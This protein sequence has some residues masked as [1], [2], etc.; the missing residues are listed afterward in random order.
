MLLLLSQSNRFSTYLYRNFLVFN[1]DNFSQILSFLVNKSVKKAENMKGDSRSSFDFEVHGSDAVL[2]SAF[3]RQ[4]K[5]FL[6]VKT[7]YKIKSLTQKS[8]M[9]TIIKVS[10]Y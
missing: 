8:R 1:L 6:P 7:K 10:T 2:E 5:L 9:L 4:S 3:G